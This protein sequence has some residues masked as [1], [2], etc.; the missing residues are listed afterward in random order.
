MNSG[1]DKHPLIRNISQ[2]ATTTTLQRAKHGPQ[3]Y[4]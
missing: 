2:V 4:K 1:H 3:E